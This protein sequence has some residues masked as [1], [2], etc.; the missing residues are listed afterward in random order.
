MDAVFDV[1]CHSRGHWSLVV[2]SLGAGRSLN[3][4]RFCDTGL[5]QHSSSDHAGFLHPECL[6]S[7]SQLIGLDTRWRPCV[8]PY[9]SLG[10]SQSGSCCPLGS[11]QT[12]LWRLPAL[13]SV[14]VCN[15]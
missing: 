11:V 10:T 3:S 4:C 12:A 6:R 8:S 14:L 1:L 9:L 2:A 7:S 13:L 5:C 15:S